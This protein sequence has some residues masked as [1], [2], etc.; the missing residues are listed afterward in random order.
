MEVKELFK[1][2]II[3]LEKKLPKKKDFI[4]SAIEDAIVIY[5]N[6]R[7]SLEQEVFSDNEKNWIKRCAEELLITEKYKGISRYS[8]NGF[9]VETYET[10]ISPNLL[11]EIVPK[12]GIPKKRKTDDPKA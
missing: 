10:V 1:K 3:F 2:E 5:R 12:V 6:R 4:E 11:N 9:S 8:E 7:R